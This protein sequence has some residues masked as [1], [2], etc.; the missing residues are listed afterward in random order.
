VERG[1][2]FHFH[3]ADQNSVLFAK[4]RGFSED[5][6]MN[7]LECPYDETHTQT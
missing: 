1:G 2:V 4:G 7:G 6:L 5:I 3:I